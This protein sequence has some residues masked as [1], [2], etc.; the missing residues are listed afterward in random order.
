[1]RS[2]PFTNLLVGLVALTVLATAGLTI[3]YVRL[4]QKL[5][6][7]QLQAAVINRNRTL[8]TALVN[9]A[10]EYSKSNPALDPILQSIGIKSKP[11]GVPS[12]GTNNR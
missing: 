2:N 8:A 6:G 12:V 11:G 1:M 3:Y 9:D 4:V 7:L 5:N 10:V